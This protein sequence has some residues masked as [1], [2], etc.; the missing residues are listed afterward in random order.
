MADKI[1]PSLKTKEFFNDLDI[2]MELNNQ[3]GFV[4]E[5]DEMLEKLLRDAI[6]TKKSIAQIRRKKKIE[7]NGEIRE[8][9]NKRQ[10]WRL[11]T[12]AYI[13]NI[14]DQKMLR[15]INA[16]RKKCKKIIKD[17]S[18][19]GI[20]HK[21]KKK[22]Y[23]EWVTLFRHLIKKNNELITTLRQKVSQVKNV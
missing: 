20:E 11:L 12:D 13:M 5:T 10:L 19:L 14:I 8:R 6:V 21:L 18:E 22:F 15:K 7:S 1:K 9:V 23:N 4:M 17:F 2:A 3:I 16:L